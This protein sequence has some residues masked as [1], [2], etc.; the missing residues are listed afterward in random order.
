MHVQSLRRV[1]R[2]AYIIVS[3][4]YLAILITGS[5]G[6]GGDGHA[7]WLARLPDPYSATLVGLPDGYYYSPAFAQVIAPLT[8]LPWPVFYALLVAVCLACLYWLVGPWA[9]PALLLP[10]VAI[11]VYSANIALPMAV[12]IVI[13]LRHPVAWAPIILT[14]VLPGV[15]VLWFAARGEW[16][17]LATALMATAAIVFVSF[18]FAPSLWWD[19]ATILRASAE[20]PSVTWYASYLLP[21]LIAAVVIVLVA[22]RTRRAWLVPVATVLAAPVLWPATLTMLLAIPRLRGSWNPDRHP[23]GQPNDVGPR[24]AGTGARTSADSPPVP[25][26]ERTTGT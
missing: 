17:S 4:V 22:A 23:A 11:E 3:V 21:R 18:L 10:P 15:G 26:T 6:G 1:A 14:K 16:R 9:L 5:S 19:W 20:T 7:Y 2:D 8:L 24:A 12:A 25:V 13:G